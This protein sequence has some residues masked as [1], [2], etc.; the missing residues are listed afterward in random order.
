MCWTRSPRPSRDARKDNLM[1]SGSF[2][3]AAVLAFL[4][5]HAGGE[6]TV[7]DTILPGQFGAA[8]T[9]Q[10]PDQRLFVTT[11]KTNIANATVVI[12]LMGTGT[13]WTVVI[14]EDTPL[15]DGGLTVTGRASPGDPWDIH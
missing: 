14:I 9:Q 3:M 10:A 5:V 6:D 1:R 7:G 13:T 4:F 11:R 12:P 15:Q 2:V 8:H